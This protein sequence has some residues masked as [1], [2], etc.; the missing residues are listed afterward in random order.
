MKENRVRNEEDKNPNANVNPEVNNK[1]GVVIDESINKSNYVPDDDFKYKDS[2]YNFK[3]NHIEYDRGRY[4]N[5]IALEKAGVNLSWRSIFAGLITFL[6]LSILFSFISATIGLGVTDL[7]SPNPLDN[8]GIGLIIWTIIS[9]IVS[10]GAGGYVAGLTANRAG[11]IHGFLTWALGLL[12]ILYL[13][14]S[15]I[16]SAFNTL[17]SLMGVAGDTMADVANI[18]GDIVYNFSQEAFDSI[19][20]NLKIDTSELDKQ[21]QDALKDSNIPELQPNY[22][23]SQ[24]DETITD[25]Q[26]AAKA[27]IVDGKDANEELNGVYQN[28]ENRLTTI[29]ESLDEEKLSNAISENTDLTDAE[30]DK[31][32]ENIKTSYEEAQ[33]QAK[34]LL[35][36][37]ETQLNQLM[38]DAEQTAEEVVET[39]DDVMNETSK[40]SFITFIGL[41]LAAILA[42]LAGKKGA[43]AGNKV[44]DGA[45]KVEKNS[46]K[47]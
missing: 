23:Q 6:A 13:A 19:S 7:T 15:T 4:L 3:E 46:L 31:A 18:S 32:V 36:D 14:T 28:I 35:A 38:E 43:E 9:F 41:T 33:E 25:I 1:K 26:N 21:V 17:G 39:T 20:D 12:A 40:Y 34:Q 11:A 47:D 8:V 5:D 42:T 30:A 10:L 29:G 2:N 45:T 22:L 16:G 27:V 37:A 44:L 24:L